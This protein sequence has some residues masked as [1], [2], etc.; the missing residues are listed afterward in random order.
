MV[1][2][3]WS[4]LDIRLHELALDLLGPHAELLDGD[5][6]AWMKGYEFALAG[7][8]Y[9]GTNEIQRNVIAERV[10][11][12]PADEGRS[13][14]GLRRRPV[15]TF[16]G[17][18][19]FSFADE[20]LALRDATRDLLAK[21]CTPGARARR[22]DERDGSRPGPVGPAR[23]HGRRRDARARIGGRARAHLRRPRARARGDGPL[24]GARTDRRDRG[25]GRAAPRPHRPHRSRRASAGCPGPTPPTSSS[26]RPA[27]SSA[28]TSMLVPPTLGRRRPPPV[29]GAGH[30]RRRST[31]SAVDG[32]VRPRR[33]RNRSPAMRVG[34]SHAGNDGRL[35][36]GAPPVRRSGRLVP[37]REAPPRQRPH[38]ARV[39]PPARVPG[40]GVDRGRRSRHGRARVDGEGQGRRRG[41]PR[42]RGSRCS[43]TAPS[44]T[45]PSTTCTSI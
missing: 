1:K 15:R 17:T 18:V 29:R 4:E 38:R 35:R 11:G 2:V 14:V 30:A 44:A 32:R 10:L 3:F 33:V 28:P 13:R 8:I 20:Q 24:R 34:R 6:A 40:R 27:A 31:P 36:A 16:G 26:P 45:R 22:V 43:A 25:V 9:A 21:E 5:D 19:Q 42:P 23:R 12:L 41:A 37:G 39:R 7:P